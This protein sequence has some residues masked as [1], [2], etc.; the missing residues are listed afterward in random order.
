M[1]LPA[2]LKSQAYIEVPFRLTRVNHIL[3]Q[4]KVNGEALP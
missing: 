2:Y 4:A 3:V 1:N